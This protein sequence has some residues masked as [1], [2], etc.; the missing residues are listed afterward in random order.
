MIDNFIDFDSG[1]WLFFKSPY[2]LEA[3]AIELIWCLKFSFK[4][5]CQKDICLAK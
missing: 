3:L 2:L 4:I 1:M 5:L